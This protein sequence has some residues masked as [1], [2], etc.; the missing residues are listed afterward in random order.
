MPAQRR[1]R[2]PATPSQPRQ[3]ERLQKTLAAAGFGSRRDCEALIL[4][5]RVDVDHR[6]VTELGTR[7][8]LHQ[9]EIRVDGVPLKVPSRIYYAL[10]KPVG[11]LCTARDP[12]GR[13][14]AI[15]LVPPEPRVFAVGRLDLHSEGLIVLTNDGDLANT[16]THP[17]FEVEKVY[18]VQVAGDMTQ[19]TINQVR[20]GMHLS[21]GF[22]QAKRIERKSH[23]AKHTWLEMILDEG[24][25][26]EIRRLLARVGHKVLTL[27]RIAVG[28]L[29]LGDLPTGAHRPLTR[30]EIAALRTTSKPA[31]GPT[32]PSGAKAR[33]HRGP[34]RA[35]RAKKVETPSSAK[36]RA[37][38]PR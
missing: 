25:N 18:R 34:R 31:A 30:E 10:N 22:V 9:Q 27:R 28:P 13:P 32:A 5:A 11:Y 35:D 37:R 24:R 19:E 38:R 23:C 20:R 17:R 6:V 1:P 21:D 2:P 12:S 14:R 4:E 15:D 16:L 36:R 7:V 26:R 29:R 8:D 3:G 33:R